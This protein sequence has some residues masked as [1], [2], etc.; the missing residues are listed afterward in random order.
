V[1]GGRVTATA[2]PVR[3]GLEVRA[4][5]AGAEGCPRAEPLPRRMTD[6]VADAVAWILA[7]LAVL[8]AVIAA[9][10]AVRLYGDGM[11]HARLDAAGR[12]S[13]QAV[14]IEPT[15]SRTPLVRISRAAPRTVV[16]V[17]VRYTSP[18]QVDHVAVVRVRGSLAAGSRVRVWVDRSGAIVAAPAG[19]GGAIRSAAGGAL[20]VLAPA[21]AVLGVVGAAVRIALA[22][23]TAAR[24]EK[25]WAQWEPRWSGRASG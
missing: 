23:A 3:V 6:R 10:T 16:S 24:W 9:T 20:G 18:D 21:A 11:R 5:S 22:R 4:M 14:L 15:T 25:E 12:T 19:P 8:T 7:S 13:V 2:R 1:A 17:P